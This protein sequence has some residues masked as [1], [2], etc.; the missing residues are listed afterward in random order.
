[1]KQLSYRVVG[2]C[3]LVIALSVI[4]RVTCNPTT[5]RP[6]YGRSSA[7][8]AHDPQPPIF[9]TLSDV[10]RYPPSE[11]TEP[12]FLP[13]PAR[14]YHPQKTHETL[15]LTPQREPHPNG[16]D[17]LN[18]SAYTLRP[19]NTTKRHPNIPLREDSEEATDNPRLN[20]VA[21]QPP[22]ED[23]PSPSYVTFYGR[24]LPRVES[25]SSEP[26]QKESQKLRPKR[27]RSMK[28]HFGMPTASTN[29]PSFKYIDYATSTPRYREELRSTTPSNI[30]DD[31]EFFHPTVGRTKDVDRARL[32]KLEDST[33]KNQK[34]SEPLVLEDDRDLTKK[35]LY[36]EIYYHPEVKKK[37]KRKTQKLEN[38]PYRKPDGDFSFIVFSES[39]PKKTVKPR[40][41][42]KAFPGKKRERGV[43]TNTTKVYYNFDYIHEPH[44]KTQRVDASNNYETTLPN[45]DIS[46]EEAT[47]KYSSKYRTKNW[48]APQES[49][50]QQNPPFLPTV[51]T[52]L[53][54]I[55][56]PE[57]E[58][59]DYDLTE[60]NSDAKS[61]KQKNAD[62]ESVQQYFQDLFRFQL[63]P[64][65]I[66]FGHVMENPKHWE[67][68][69]ERNDMKN[70]RHQGKVR[71]GDK[72]GGYGEHVWD[73]NHHQ[74]HQQP[75][76]A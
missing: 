70:H 57:V 58:E 38:Q 27:R 23:F 67:E 2:A 56:K 49:S 6:Q 75:K 50:G 69:Y 31:V 16:F 3:L 51:I 13:I 71:W 43:I 60:A 72:E 19:V 54:R 35:I 1:M 39:N 33:E 21:T 53:V 47:E 12:I 63:E 8:D 76:S 26:V 29:L 42:L 44:V 74:P 14:N 52:P 11:Y 24:I 62:P 34:Y 59:E 7:N 46:A 25:N 40:S 22:P 15:S 18:F 61:S 45:P 28:H 64:H 66:E 37:H 73:L 9:N 48:K 55:E 65:A 68:R 30:Y 17:L 36:D 4:D 20:I 32:V 10:Q 41:K 5:V